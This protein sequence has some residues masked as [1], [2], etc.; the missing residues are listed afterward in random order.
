MTGESN[1]VKSATTTHLISTAQRLFDVAARC[2]RGAAM[3]EY[4]LL[5]A[6][7]ALTAI[8]VL[9]LFGTSLAGVFSDAE[10]TISGAGNI[11]DPG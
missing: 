6:L 5:L 3:T 11:P 2:Q 1:T 10:S 7:V 8:G 4:G 9:G